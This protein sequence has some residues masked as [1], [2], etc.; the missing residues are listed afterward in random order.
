MIFD[1]EISSIIFD[2]DIIEERI[3]P[4]LVPNAKI[5]RDL[6][7]CHNDLFS[8]NII[9]ND[10]TDQIS[11]I[12]FE[13]THF[14]YHLFD[15]AHHFMGYVFDVDNVDVDLYPTRDEQKRWLKIYFQ[16][17][18]I[19]ESIVNDDLCHLIDQ[20]STLLFLLLGLWALVQSRLSQ[21][22]FDY[23]HH[24]K[25]SLDYY[26]KQRPILYFNSLKIKFDFLLI[27]SIKNKNFKKHS[28][29]LFYSLA[30]RTSK[31]TKRNVSSLL[32]KNIFYVN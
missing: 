13:Y 16:T 3:L 27:F 31:Y 10:K 32:S 17:R 6:V 15:I 25:Q 1:L 24:A 18:Q 5:G 28:E 26:R 22:D 8:N 21:L 9:Y 23:V 14:N 7:L 12:D 11:L 4:K 30:K 2:V 29:F 19:D 20:F